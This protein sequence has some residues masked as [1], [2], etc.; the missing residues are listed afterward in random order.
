[1]LLE[2]PGV[3]RGAVEAGTEL[4]RVFVLPDDAAGRRLAAAASCEVVAVTPQVLGAIAGSE[5]PRGPVAVA[6]RPAWRPLRNVP[7]LVLWELGDP[8]NVGTLIRSAVAFGF[9]VGIV[10]GTADP[11]SPKALRAAAGAHFAA[12]LG[13][14]SGLDDLERVG[15]RPVATVPR[16][17]QPPGRVPRGAALAVLV[18]NEAH[19]LPADV[20]AAADLRVTVP[21]RA[22]VESLNAATAAAIVMYELGV[23]RAG[24]GTGHG[25]GDRG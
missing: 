25:A 3:V 13:V 11:W 17:G 1:M 24:P 22:G 12:R 23:R 15:L 20:L 16:G 8:G 21:T 14:V 7:T 19:G 9:D 10:A 2:G 6:V 18:G 5:H 4:V